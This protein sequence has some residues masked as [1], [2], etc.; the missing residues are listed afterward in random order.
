[1]LDH[2]IYLFDLLGLVGAIAFWNFSRRGDGAASP[3]LVAVGSVLSILIGLEV[4]LSVLGKTVLFDPLSFQGYLFALLPFAWVAL[5]PLPGEEDADTSFPRLFLPLLAVLQALHAFPVAGSQMQ[6]STFLLIPVGALC[7]A[8]GARGLARTF[9]GRERQA[10]AAV[11]VAAAA[12]MAVALVNTQLR[13]PLRAAEAGYDERE[14]LALPGAE[15]V[16]LAPEEAA[17]Y[18]QVTEAIDA[19][20]QSMLMLP[21]MN[22]FYLWAER[23]PPTGYNATGWSTLFDAAHQE[24]VI[25]ETSSIKHLCLL[26]NDS[27]ARLW[28][29]G[30]TP[31]GA[32]VSYLHRGFREIG[33]FGPYRLLRR[34]GTGGAA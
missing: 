2:R 25:D 17:L 33:T 24:R 12:V 29:A 14:S 23:E 32:L 13:Q 10:L 34:E 15:D 28:T 6:W 5:V 8:K 27:A 7:V 22:S 30:A 16:H 31:E 26:E 9:V 18:R 11:G 1:V 20:C 19:N 21:G 3:A 4:A